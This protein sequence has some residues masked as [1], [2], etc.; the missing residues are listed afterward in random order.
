MRIAPCPV[1]VSL[2]SHP[3][4]PFRP[5]RPFRGNV[6][7]LALALVCGACGDAATGMPALDAQA[8]EAPSDTRRLDAPSDAAATTDTSPDD[9]RDA[10]PADA[11]REPPDVEPPDALAPVDPGPVNDVDLALDS[12]NLFLGSGGIGFAYGALTPAAQLPLG[13]V[14][15]GPDTTSGL[16]RPVF[17]HFS[18]YHFD[19]PD[20]LGFSHTHFIGTGVPDFGNFRFLAVPAAEAD[21]ADLRPL[22]ARY[23]GMDKTTEAASPGRY[24]VRLPEVGVEVQLTAT[25]HAGLQRYTFDAAGPA[26]LVFNATSD[27]SGEGGAREGRVVRSAE[28][29]GVTAEIL[30]GGSYTGRNPFRFHFDARFEPPPSRVLLVGPDGTAAGDQAEGVPS[31]AV[32]IWDSLPAERPVIEVRS[33]LSWV[34]AAQ[35]RDH[36][37]DELEGV[38]FEAV[39]TAARAAWADKV[40]RARIAGGTPEQRRIFLTSLYNAYRMPTELAGGDGRYMGFDR[41]IHTAVGFR[42]LTNLSL[43]DTFRTLHPWYSLT[44]HETQRDCLQSLM[45]MGEQGGYIPRWPAGIGYTNGMIGTN[46][47][48]VFADAALKGVAQVDYEAAY[49]RL[50]LTA[51][52]PTSPGHSFSGR[53]GITEYLELGY[54]P[55]DATDD[56]V[57]KTLEYAN[58][59][60]ALSKLAAFLGHDADAADFALR[61][62]YWRNLFNEEWGFAFPKSRE[63]VSRPVAP[64]NPTAPYTEGTAW[65]WTF[66]VPQDPAGLAA[67]FGGPVPF[68]EKLEALFALSK[69]GQTEGRVRNTFPDSHY[70]HGNE[71][72]IQAGYLFGWSDRPA[73]GNYWLREIQTRLYG[74]AG[75]GL[76]GNDDGGTLSSWY[77]FSALGLYPIAGTPDYMLGTP[78]FPRAEVD[79]AGGGMLR[80][81]AP[82]AD[83]ERRYVRRVTWNGER[84]EG[85]TIDHT[86]L[87]AG[88]T[89]AFE[90]SAT[91]P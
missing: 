21:A 59:D 79:L 81:E 4:R 18:G 33:G 32:A 85:P 30:F 20:T 19:D 68:G 58:D 24:S 69:L 91:P 73:R 84:V 27:A 15:L 78:L 46:A 77:L 48:V 16:S 42:Y 22:F 38:A 35:A 26:A 34:D 87:A 82:G 47:D 52:A 54:L 17:H 89:L 62:G 51:N 23:V 5:F 31:G 57:S 11:R 55:E 70:W 65:Q 29:D 64:Q 40:R 63:G 74:D 3:I 72:V 41:Q 45:A 1:R 83:V 12:A 28:G 80:I 90:M 75:D 61:S 39:A 13:M 7:V 67:A 43:W 86:R 10:R 8:G 37:V 56:S 9:L 53:E 50:L 44:D 36:R 71:P 88:G 25:R 76:A 66:F 6:F 14:S 49:Q 2:S 60:N